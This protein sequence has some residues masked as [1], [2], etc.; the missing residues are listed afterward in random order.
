[1]PEKRTLTASARR[2]SRSRSIIR[3]RS[4]VRGELGRGR[5]LYNHYPHSALAPF[6]TALLQY[7]TLQS[8]RTFQQFLRC[9]WAR[10]AR[11]TPERSWAVDFSLLGLTLVGNDD[12]SRC[13][14]EQVNK[15]VAERAR[16]IRYFI[17][18]FLT[19]DGRHISD[20]SVRQCGVPSPDGICAFLLIGF[21][22]A[23]AYAFFRFLK[24]DRATCAASCV[25]P[26]NYG[27]YWARTSL[28]VDNQLNR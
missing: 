6:F 3:I 9:K 5:H 7:A 26:V 10:E 21:S 16:V 8:C 24:S 27:H 18:R 13:S 14:I 20:L 1:M 22:A 28:R 4:R 19:Q 2:V 25:S 11:L 17:I 15:R 23:K 12:K